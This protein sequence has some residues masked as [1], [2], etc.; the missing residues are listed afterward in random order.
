LKKIYVTGTVRINFKPV[1]NANVTCKDMTVNTDNQGNFHFTI[2]PDTWEDSFPPNSYYGFHNLQLT[3]EK[4]GEVIK[5]TPSIL[6]YVCSGGSI[7]W[8][9]FVIKSRS[10]TPTLQNGFSQIFYNL[11]EMLSTIFP[12]I[13]RNIKRIDAQRI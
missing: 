12:S 13:F 1:K 5:K 2:D 4:D 11:L 10:R 6:S 7:N 8:P 9:I 3:I